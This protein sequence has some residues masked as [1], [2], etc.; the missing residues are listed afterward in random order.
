MLN[1]RD[2]TCFTKLN[3]PQSIYTRLY[4]TSQSC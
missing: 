3:N 4:Q 1:L 2:L